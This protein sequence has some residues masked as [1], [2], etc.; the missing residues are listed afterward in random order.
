YPACES[1]PKGSCQTMC[2]TREMRQRESQ[3]RLHHYEMVLGTRRDRLPRADPLRTVKEYT[4]PAAGKDS[5]NPS[6]L[7]PAYVLIKTV[8][9]LI[10]A[11]VYC[12]V[13]DR[14][15]AVKQDMIIQRLSGKDCVTILER[16]VRFLVYASYRLCGEPLGFYDPKIND[17]HVQENL[18][19]LLDCYITAPTPYDN[20]EEFEALNLLYNLGCTQVL[21]RVLQ[22]PRGLRST[23][24]ISL[25]LSINQAFLERNPVRLL[26][27]SQKLNFLQSCALH[28]HLPTCRSDLLLIYSH[29]FSSRNCRFPLEKLSELMDLDK[30]YTTQYCQ[31][32]GVEINQENKVIFV[33]SAFVEPEQRKHLPPTSDDCWNCLGFF[34]LL[35]NETFCIT[36]GWPLGGSNDL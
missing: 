1:V 28:R 4:R 21:Q 7:R 9:H 35:L 24:S 3:H 17:M 25:A 14:L 31:M 36:Q 22:L 10:D 19:W 34:F 32:Y 18:S 30:C 12:F 11:I 16:T 33:R 26:R 5:T 20:Q 8:C 29:G 6:D 13:F 27:L 2:P 15:R 23:P